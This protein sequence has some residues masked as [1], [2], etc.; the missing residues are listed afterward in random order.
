MPYILRQLRERTTLA[1]LIIATVTVTPA[2]VMTQVWGGPTC[3]N[4]YDGGEGYDNGCF[5]GLIHYNGLGAAVWTSFILLL[6]LSPYLVHGVLGVPKI[7]DLIARS[8]WRRR[9][10]FLWLE[11]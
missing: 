9:Y 10:L 4:D 1:I 5:G 8:G 6:F 11:S 7:P 2:V 3:V